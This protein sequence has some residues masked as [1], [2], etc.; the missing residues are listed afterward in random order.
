MS[1]INVGLRAALTLSCAVISLATGVYSMPAQAQVPEKSYSISTQD[2]GAALR[3]FAIAS[4][5]DVVFSPTLVRGKTT[6]GVQGSLSDEEALTRLLAGSG[7]T[8]ERTATGGFVVRPAKEAN[9]AA[10][11]ADSVAASTNNVFALDEVIVTGTTGA[12]DKFTAPYA[13]STI[14]EESM[15][16]KSPRSLADLLRN[17][18]GISVENSGGEGGFENLVIRGLPYIGWRLFDVQ[19]DGL[20]LYESPWEKYLNIDEIFRVDLMTERAEIVEGGTAPIFDNNGSGGYMNL[21]TRHGTPTP[22][23]ALQV[24]GGTDGLIKVSG[25]QSGPITDNLLYSVGG[26]YRRDDGLRDQGFNGDEGGQIQAGA[27]YLLP[28]N[29]GKLFADVKY[30]NDKSIIYTDI[31]L[32]NPLTGGSLSGLLNPNTGTLDSSSENNVNIRTLNGTPGGATIS[33]NLSNGIHPNVTTLTAGGDFDLGSGWQITDRARYTDG[34]IGFNGIFNGSTPLNAATYLGTF[35]TKAQTAFPGTTSLDYSVVGSGTAYNPATT[36]GLV[37]VNSF[38]AI[39]TKISD[40]INDVHAAKTFDLSDTVKDDLTVGFYSSF[41]HFA[42]REYIS[43]LLNNVENNPDLLDIRALSASG[44]VLGSVTEN[45]FLSYGSNSPNGWVDGTSLA[46]Y[47]ENALHITPPWQVDGGVRYESRQ[48][49]GVTDVDGTQDVEP[50]GP[51]AARS[52]QGVVGYAAESQTQDGLAYTIGTAYDISSNLNVYARY[53]HGYSFP[54]M[55]TIYADVPSNGLLP[56]GQ[57][58]PVSTVN[59]A[60]GGL[61]FKTST[62]QTAFTVY[63]SHF[64]QLSSTAQV[65][66]PA[67]NGIVSD[68]IV[69][70]STTYGAS[71][72]ADWRPVRAFDLSGIVTLQDPKIDAVQLICVT[73]CVSPSTVIG[74]AIPRVPTYYVSLQPAYIFE[75]RNWHGRAFADIA[76]T[77]K[78]FQDISNFSILP[79]YTAL[80]LGVTASPTDR[81]ELRLLATNVTNS[82]GLTEGNARGS[83][84]GVGTVGDS[85]V[86]RPIFGRQ[87]IGSIMYHW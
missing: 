58:V 24:E 74:N 84:L 4:G 68:P 1:K 60:E 41:Y 46:G 21:I 29:K 87:V 19:E 44:S 72:E 11:D 83:A 47:L 37:M 5:R 77:G 61:K 71:A 67:T 64:N 8:F 79:A 15:L 7:L 63:Y 32:T 13:V 56:N 25:Y 6:Q 36:A 45:G 28:D 2:L 35:L 48:Q 22:E 59:Q 55:T 50:T 23:G 49:H 51:L 65:F 39:Q 62:F 82:A 80:D 34:T 53:S 52:V 17:E 42:Q 70:S 16:D 76:I 14:K 69:F 75:F 33:E 86:G 26:F 27:T 57:P 81:V 12:I 40:L 73:V 54:Q 30:L 10:L 85:T 9:S 66:N 20:P 38:Y 31:P 18:P 3:A 43:T 78:R